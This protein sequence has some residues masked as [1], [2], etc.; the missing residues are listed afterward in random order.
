MCCFDIPREE[1]TKCV[2]KTFWGYRILNPTRLNPDVIA[3]GE[4]PIVVHGDSGVLVPLSSNPHDMFGPYGYTSLKSVEDVDAMIED[5]RIMNTQTI[6]NFIQDC[7]RFHV[8]RGKP[9]VHDGSN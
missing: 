8:R 7:A 2:R 4:G 5:R 3:Y 9:H 6:E 1:A